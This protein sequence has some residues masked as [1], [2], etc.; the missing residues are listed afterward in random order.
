MLHAG[1]RKVTKRFI[2]FSPP[3]K[4]FLKIF[5]PTSFT[6][7]RLRQ[8]VQSQQYKFP[9]ILLVFFYYCFGQK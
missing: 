7:Y 2:Y 4:C 3:T 6:Q 1:H 5:L 9:D 8:A